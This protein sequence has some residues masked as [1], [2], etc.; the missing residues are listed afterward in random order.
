MRKLFKLI[1]KRLFVTNTSF[2]MT[3]ASS[4]GLFLGI[5]PIIGIRIPLLVIISI[6]FKLNIFALI[7]GMTITIVFPILHVISFTIAQSIGGYQIPFFNL[8]YLTIS[9]LIQWTETGRYQFIGSLLTGIML[10]LISFPFFKWFYSWRQNNIIENNNKRFIFK[11]NT[12]QRWGALKKYV[13]VFIM[14]LLIIISV[15]GISLSINPFLPSMGL[16][17]IKNL[18]HISSISLNFDPKSSI[19]LL[20]QYEKRKATFQLDF[21]KHNKAIKSIKLQRKKVFAFFVDWDE[22]SFT[23]LK[24]NVR[25]INVVIPNWYV[26]NTDLSFKNN[27][28]KEVDDFIK[29]NNVMN[30]PL[31]NNYV[32]NKWDG[33]L[34]HKLLANV[35][36]KTEFLNNL[37][38]D[39][40]ING[41]SG[42]NIDF[43]SI[44]SKDKTL[45]TLFMKELCTKFHSNGLKVSMDVPAQ[46][47]AFDY[48]ALS[49]SVDYMIVMMYDEHYDA[50]TPGPIASDT[51]F[52]NILDKIDIPANKLVVS[53]GNY[54]YDWNITN[55]D[56]ADSVTFGDVIDMVNSYHLKIN[57]DSNSG[58]P[59]M[60]YIDS[61]EKHEVWLLD[62]ATMYNQLKTSVENGI[63]GAALWRLGSEDPTIWNMLK[64]MDH[65]RQNIAKLKVLTS[66]YPVHYSGEGEILRVLSRGNVGI[67]N[68][69]LDSQADGDIINE[70]YKKYPIPFEVE[71]YG[72]PKSKEVVLT[73]D[74]G[75][76]PTYTPKIL[77]ILKRYNVKATFFIVGENGAANPDII[78]REYNEGNELGNHTYTH[79]NVAD[80]SSSRTRIELNTT[81]RLVQ[82]L[83][84]H[85]MIMFRPPYVAD[86]EP[87]TPNELL[88]ILRAQAEGYTMIGELID[89][90]D[91]EKP[92]SKIILDRILKDLPNGNIILL[93]DAGGNRINTVNALPNI[94]VTLRKM[95]YSFVGIHDLIGKSRDAVMPSIKS[96]DN[97]FIVYDRALFSLVFSW[98]LFIKI[99]FYLAI[100]LG[101]FRFLFLIFFSVKQSKKSNKL[102]YDEKFNPLVTVVVAA[103]NEEKVICKTVDSIL[104]SDYKNLEIIIVNDGSKDN[105]GTI[106]AESYMSNPKVMLINKENSGKASSVNVGFRAARGEIIVALDADTIIAKDAIKLLIRHFVNKDIA[107]VSGNV[108]VGNV[109]NL[110]TLWQHVEYITG[111]NLERRAFAELNCITVVPGAI[112]AWRKD[113]VKEAGYFKEDTLAEDTDITL[114]LLRKGYK[115]AYEEYAY[116]YTESPGDIKSLLK[117]R[118]RWAYGTLQ[119][120]WKHKDALFNPEHKTLGFVALP[121][122]WVFQYL[123]QS[124]SPLADIYFV[125]GL[126]G[127]STL[128]IVIFY[129]A[130]LL[131]DYASSLIAFRLEKE[132]PKPLIWL[133]LQRLIYRQFMTYVV[134]KSIFSALM[135]IT[136]GWNKLQRKGNVKT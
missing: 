38:K 68:Y 35:S 57:W 97:P 99:L 33:L 4:L 118:Y 131:L 124:L 25:D 16:K 65:V 83:T 80:I 133:F 105:T 114:N 78:E 132:N 104:N 28:T 21:K 74:D 9:H 116:A 2:K 59:Y 120:L 130:F 60:S 71:R 75:P 121:N 45:L 15:F 103:Y 17:S 70:M 55:K 37:E 49:S 34:I 48:S 91:W 50:G 129:L 43:E 58:N 7:A 115:I 87:S 79:P 98:E 134:I 128:K 110:L 46:D 67:R 122:M 27:K 22:N 117:Q 66:P 53:L 20:K 119:C 89:P 90:S 30:M 19:N 6:I 82:E 123:F 47:N 127:K 24:S 106:V 111:F 109:S 94:I 39:I 136:V 112:G 23:S 108:K 64:D 135:G 125:V 92:S 29:G 63:C 41:Y 32:G 40:K 31:I 12:G 126:F 101:I 3:V 100:C 11:D 36:L 14:I 69:E 26:L 88:P 52:Q 93:H 73:F 96:S 5:L 102:I 62:G 42:I 77:D 113:Y 84:G 10:A 95:G 44:D 51:W 18:A 56:I 107:A 85:S 8:R 72:K 13:T 1:I 54:G 86:A 61:G 76:D 81:Q